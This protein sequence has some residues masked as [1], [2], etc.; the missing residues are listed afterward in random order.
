M[1]PLTPAILL[2]SASLAVAFKHG[3]D[4]DPLGRA[5]HARNFQAR[6]T[7]YKLVDYHGPQDFM[8]ER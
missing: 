3:E 7:E 2:A 6:S 5:Q 1:R 4:F 8:N